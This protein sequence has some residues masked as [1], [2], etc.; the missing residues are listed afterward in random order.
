MPTQHDNSWRRLSPAPELTTVERDE[1][2]VF[3]VQLAR[4]IR[5]RDLAEFFNN[6]AG[7][8]H[9]AMIVGDRSTGKHKG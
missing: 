1:R 6:N 2:T 4:N 7:K 3:C 9:Q 5:P 8:V